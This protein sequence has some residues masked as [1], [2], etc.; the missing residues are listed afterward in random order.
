MSHIV[1]HIV[2]NIVGIKNP[3][4]SQDQVDFTLPTDLG[5]AESRR[6]RTLCVGDSKWTHQRAERWV[7]QNK[8]QFLFRAL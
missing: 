5:E 8:E 7:N 2:A 6:K 4:F 3:F 1:L